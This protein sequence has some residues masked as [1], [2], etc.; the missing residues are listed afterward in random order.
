MRNLD[1]T[2]IPITFA[3]FS[4]VFVVW[5]LRRAAISQ[6]RPPPK[7]RYVVAPGF[8][9]LLIVVVIIIRQFLV[10]NA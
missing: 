6:G 9:A 10:V 2:V 3:V 5:C 7:W 4:S 1:L 8:A